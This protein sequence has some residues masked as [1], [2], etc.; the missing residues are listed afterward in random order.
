MKKVFLV[1]MLVAVF[2]VPAYAVSAEPGGF[3]IEL[4]EKK[5]IRDTEIIPFS[6]NGA[7]ARTNIKVRIHTTKEVWAF[8]KT[9]DTPDVFK[10]DLGIWE[11]D[12]IVA[13]KQKSGDYPVDLIMSLRLS[14][15]TVKRV[16][17]H[18]EVISAQALS[19]EANALNQLRND[20]VDLVRNQYWPVDENLSEQFDDVLV[21]FASKHMHKMTD[22]LPG[23]FEKQDQETERRVKILMARTEE[24]SS[25]VS[26]FEASIR[27]QFKSVL[28]TNEKI[29][30]D[31]DFV[32]V[33]DKRGPRS[34]SPILAKLSPISISPQY[35]R[36]VQFDLTALALNG[37]E[38]YR[39]AEVAYHEKTIQFDDGQFRTNFRLDVRPMM[40]D[41]YSFSK[42]FEHDGAFNEKV[43]LEN[44]KKSFWQKATAKLINAGKAETDKAERAY[45]VTVIE[46]II[47]SEQYA[48]PEFLAK[49]KYS[50]QSKST[51]KELRKLR[52]KL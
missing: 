6:D 1:S 49:A 45:I 15:G 12:I 30:E 48:F 36:S 37:V 19:R 18:L 31:T 25:Q 23:A 5:A 2:C 8:E 51:Q 20:F 28:K 42:N 10:R 21:R 32:Q 27:S 26:D 38:R 17:R 35:S 52:K 29:E 16:E 13:P 40:R 7:D 47:F 43:F 22:E 11:S 9:A 46:P 44:W 50:F 4:S 24:A 41:R 33:D 3:R 39:V 14:N 34:A